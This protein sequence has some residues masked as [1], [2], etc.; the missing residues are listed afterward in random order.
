MSSTIV[1]N[2]IY[3][4]G[5]TCVSCEN[6]IE[7]KLSSTEGITGVS[8]RYTKGIAEIT[9]DTAVIALSDIEKIIEDLDYKVKR[10][11]EI[12]KKKPDVTNLLAIVITVYAIYMLL[13]R[14]TG[15]DFFNAF[16]L[17][18]EGMGY[19][20]LF[21][22]GVLTSVHCVAMCG[23]ICLSQCVP[24]E[25]ENGATPSKWATLR[26]SLLYNLGRVTSYTIIGAI[27]GG[28][29]SVI[30]FSGTMKGIV[31]ILAGV[32]MVI[33]GLNMLSLFPGLRKFVPHMPKVFAK[34]IY[35]RKRSNSPYYIGLLNG[36]M[37]CGPLQA[38]Q[39]YALSTGNPLQG[40]ISMF[41]FSVGTVPLM[42]GF[43][44]LSS[45]LNKKFTHKMLSASAVLVVILGIFML[46]NGFSLSGITM[47]SLTGI[48]GSAE[49]NSGSK[50]VAVIEDGVQIV[51]TS[52]SS[53]RYEPI[54]VQKGIP[55]K[56]TIIAE[57]NDIN[58]CNNSMVI[59]KYGIQYDFKAGDNVVE[60]TPTESGTIPYSCWMGM[61]RSKITVVDN[62]EDSAA[63]SDTSGNEVNG[64]S[65][66]Q[67]I[68][69]SGE[70]Q[71]PTDELAIA[72][73]KDG[74]QYVKID[75]DENGFKP[76]VVVMQKGIETTWIIN[77]LEVNESNNTIVFPVYY[78]Q[79]GIL[80]GENKVTLTPEDDFD[81]YPVGSNFFGYVKVV[82]DIT[83]IDTKAIKEEVSAY[84]PSV[85]DISD[86]AGLPSCH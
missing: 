84:V 5:M 4:E 45:L 78:A 23:G 10:T 85:Q 60:F 83:N 9:Y 76:A 73:I 8:V 16:P 13:K 70:S 50:N 57:D 53:G 66:S 1:N 52:L 14:F 33:M 31:Q 64:N 49:S 30:S 12:E 86:G 63:S 22:I 42:F 32:F 27:V 29:G 79:M 46:N 48:M 19:G 36:L 54:T 26:P 51:T 81:F 38:M 20:M 56:W 67:T 39:L 44:V 6:R 71:I 69:P 61:I 15:F 11:V 75:M 77:G 82:E 21:L 40:A 28:I 24:K 43:G 7:R 2:T 72:E 34:L 65:D 3:I 80:E 55:V 47:P 25:Q 68:I 18:E 37:P 58:G 17:A 74:K 41:L 62:L 59:P 35:G